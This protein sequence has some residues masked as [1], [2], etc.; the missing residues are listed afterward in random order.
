[1]FQAYNFPLGGEVAVRARARST[2][3]RRR[4]A[5]GGFSSSSPVAN[6]R[7]EGI[8]PHSAR[9]VRERVGVE[10]RFARQDGRKFERRRVSADYARGH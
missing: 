4:R 10:G 6:I 8:F 5:N 7:D 3:R 1:M 2:K 9:N